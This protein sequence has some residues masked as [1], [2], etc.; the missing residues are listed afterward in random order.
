MEEEALEVEA[1]KILVESLIS[2]KG[3]VVGTPA[4]YYPKKNRK[5]NIKQNKVSEEVLN[6]DQVFIRDFVPV[7]LLFLIKG[8][9]DIKLDGGKEVNVRGKEIVQDFLEMT[10]ELHQQERPKAFL[11]TGR[12]L[13]PASFKIIKNKNGKEKL[14]PDFG[15]HAIARV[16]PVD[17]SLW[18]IIL[19]RAYWKATGNTTLV[20]RADFQEG[21]RL[22]LE[23]CFSDRFD[24]EPT[25]LVPD[26]ACMIDRRMG[27]YGHPLE[28]QVLFYAAMRAADELLDRKNFTNKDIIPAVEKRVAALANHIRDEYWMDMVR[29]NKIYQYDVEEYGAT[30]I[31][32]YNI[33]ASS[34]PYA[35]LDEWLSENSGYLVG[36][37]GAS[38]IDFRFFSLGN[39]MAIICSL[40]RQDQSKA[41]M[42]LIKE[43]R[44]YLIGKMPLKICYAALEGRDWEIVTGCDPK[45]R[46]W[47]YHNGGSW[48][49]LMWMLAAAAR[50][51]SQ[52]FHEEGYINLTNKVIEAAGKRL[53]KDEWPEYYDG[54]S[55]HLIGR[56]ARKNQTW[57]IAGYL[58]AKE[59][60][61]DSG[62]KHL[63][64]IK[65]NE[66]T[67]RKKSSPEAN[68]VT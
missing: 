22:I 30:A 40:V 11:N 31:N 23:L 32:K 12:V 56:E 61:A 26:G 54:L 25:L 39:L 51:V 63:E 62:L 35:N 2:Y 24:R 13:M 9:F 46:H 59:L 6:Y 27:I 7:A 21:I 60:L 8:D 14:E 53:K 47:S 52:E 43:R 37:L 58:L 34:I 64:L 42:Q 16:T 5:S 55:G 28:I 36:N 17:S 20:H 66:K 19:L 68:K 50:K 3:R 48:P 18:W 33:Y 38:Q 41:I 67:Y 29:L 57:T 10:L 49:V 44:Q 15:Q 4:A 65:F 45:N 1:L